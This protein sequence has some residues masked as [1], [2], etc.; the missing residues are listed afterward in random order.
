MDKYN[1]P[2]ELAAI[3][4][5]MNNYIQLESCGTPTIRELGE[6]LIEKYKCCKQLLTQQRRV[7]NRMKRIIAKQK[8]SIQPSIISSTSR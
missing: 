3:I 7:E 1:T 6:E 8:D 5:E 4:D 2:Q